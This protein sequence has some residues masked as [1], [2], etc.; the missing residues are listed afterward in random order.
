MA[1][2]TYVCDKALTLRFY[3]VG[4][5]RKDGR[6]RF[7]RLNFCH[8]PAPLR[9]TVLGGNKGGRESPEMGLR[10]ARVPI[11][12]ALRPWGYLIAGEGFFSVFAGSSGRIRVIWMV[13]YSEL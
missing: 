4:K 5:E 10:G 13:L 3:E 1:S 11:P 2:G 7:R 8:L 6:W 12:G 9:G